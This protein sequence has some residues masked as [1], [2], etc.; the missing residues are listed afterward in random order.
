VTDILQQGLHKA[1]RRRRKR[2]T[3]L[4]GRSRRRRRGTGGPRAS[5]RHGHPERPWLV[6]RRKQAREQ[7]AAT[8]VEARARG[9]EQRTERAAG[10]RGRAGGGRDRR[11]RV[12]VGHARGYCWS[13]EVEKQE[14]ACD[15]GRHGA[16]RPA[17]AGSS[18][19]L[20]CSGQARAAAAPS[21]GRAAAERKARGCAQLG[22]N[23]NAGPPQD[24]CGRRRTRRTRS[25]GA[26]GEEGA[27]QHTTGALE[28]RQ[29][30]PLQRRS[31]VKCAARA[32][33]AGSSATGRR[34]GRWRESVDGAARETEPAL[35]REW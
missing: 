4:H 14:R 26:R 33:R 10:R 18:R 23:L 12:R 35:A 31:S 24:R 19:R 29:M 20:R 27:R 21:H 17:R 11:R 1:P 22:G 13:G 6:R 16:G 2:H 15:G 3:C 8:A 28:T 7:R 32:G 5:A 30:D 9:R 34:S 25:G